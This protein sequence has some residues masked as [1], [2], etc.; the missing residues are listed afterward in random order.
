MLVSD[1]VGVDENDV[2]SVG[3]GLGVCVVVSVVVCVGSD[4][5]DDDG[6]IVFVGVTVL[7]GV[8]V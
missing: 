6:V 4:V 5:T 7:L 3:V 2:V 1:I 8:P